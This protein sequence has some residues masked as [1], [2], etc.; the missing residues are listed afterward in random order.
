[1]TLGIRL[2]AWISIVLFHIILI[3]MKTVS[4]GTELIR[5]YFSFKLENIESQKASGSPINFNLKSCNHLDLL[6]SLICRDGYRYGIY[7]I[8]V[9]IEII[10]WIG[11]HILSNIS[12]F[13]WFELPKNLKK[14]RIVESKIYE[15]ANKKVGK[16]DYSQ[17]KC[18]E[19]NQ[20]G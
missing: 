1:M 11:F 6:R 2:I 14:N 9:A 4:T 20:L 3:T 10:V 13:K 8:S 19:L 15:S 5:F 16:Y 7:F 17:V 18:K 12:L